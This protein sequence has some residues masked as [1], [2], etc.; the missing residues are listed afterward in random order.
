MKILVWI[1]QFQIRLSRSKNPLCIHFCCA[2]LKFYV[3]FYVLLAPE[4]M[5]KTIVAIV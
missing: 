1:V 5:I 3:V 2:V 4:S